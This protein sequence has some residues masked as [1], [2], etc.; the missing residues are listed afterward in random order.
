MLREIGTWRWEKEG[1]SAISTVIADDQRGIRDEREYVQQVQES[2]SKWQKKI[3]IK[4][5]KR[6]II[7]P[8]S[9]IITKSTASRINLTT[10]LVILVTITII[11]VVAIII[12][13]VG[14]IRRRIYV[15][16]RGR[17]RLWD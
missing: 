14:E 2:Q 3:Q 16:L 10:D 7:H 6:I 15:G 13:V 9:A 12:V 17:N 8:E 1:N 11:T 5:I 4:P